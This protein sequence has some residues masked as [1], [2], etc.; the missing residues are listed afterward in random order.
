[1]VFK[2]THGT[3]GLSLLLL[4]AVAAVASANTF[5]E[6]DWIFDDG[7]ILENQS[8]KKLFP[9]SDVL[10][11]PRNVDRPLVSLSLAINFAISAHDHWSYSAFNVL[12]HAVAAWI[13]FLLARWTLSREPL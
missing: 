5:G 3:A 8:L 9:L 13:L 11:D 7:Q 10:F 6:R 4:L 1:M 2:K 12:V